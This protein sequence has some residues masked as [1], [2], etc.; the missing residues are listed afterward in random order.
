MFGIM[1]MV[2]VSLDSFGKIQ[3]NTEK[4]IWRFQKKDYLPLCPLLSSS[5]QVS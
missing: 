2:D 3:N 5:A 4:Y 1:W